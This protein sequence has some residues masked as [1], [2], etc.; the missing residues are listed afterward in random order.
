MQHFPLNLLE[1]RKNSVVKDKS[2]GALLTD[3]LKT[4]ECLD[5]ELLTAKLNTYGF[6]LPA[7]QLK[8]DENYSQW[9]KILFGVP[10]GSILGPRLFN[11]FLTDLFFVIEGIDIQVMQ[12]AIRPL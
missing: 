10:Q 11:I 8:I 5:H 6:T 12:M 1:K 4:F 2:F 9:L 7:L 3:L